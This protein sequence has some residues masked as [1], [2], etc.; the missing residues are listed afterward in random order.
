[1][2]PVFRVL[3]VASTEF[4]LLPRVPRRNNFLTRDEHFI[5]SIVSR[6]SAL[7]ISIFL[8]LSERCPNVL[9]SQKRILL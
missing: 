8:A 9:A 5:A 3:A 2:W 1:V 6:V 7:S 4:A